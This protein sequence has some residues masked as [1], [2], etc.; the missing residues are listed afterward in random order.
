MRRRSGFTLI[1]L[2][3]VIA[4]IGILA[5]I[6]L[7]ALSRAREAARR[8]SCANNLKQWGLMFKMF[9]NENDGMFPAANQWMVN[10][11][12]LGINAMGDLMSEI[13]PQNY[14]PNGKSG[15]SAALYPDYWT[16]PNIA[17][18]PS[19]PRSDTWVAGHPHSGKFGIEEDIAAQ[20]ARMNKDGSWPCKAAMNVILS[21]PTSYIYMP[22]AIRSAS[23]YMDVAW[24]LASAF[25]SSADWQARPWPEKV[26]FIPPADI[27]RC[28]GP[29][30]WDLSQPP[31]WFRDRGF[32]DI[33]VSKYPQMLKYTWQNI[34]DRD[35][36]NVTPLPDSYRRLREGIERFFI[37]DINNPAAGAL[38]Q[39]T[40]PCMWDA[41]ANSINWHGDQGGIAR[42]N[43]IPGGS[44]VLY[45]DGHVEFIK[46]QEKFPVIAPPITTQPG[47][48]AQG[49]VYMNIWGGMG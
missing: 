26:I 38:A 14:P 31:L 21:N 6:L 10:Q 25:T 32:Q 19:D 27:E 28:G 47:A 2:L 12:T 16:D 24:W 37:T 13:S 1:E 33:T 7:P 29:S 3:V 42:F 18:C 8:A 35:D 46:F 43:H 11:W 39:S 44:N 41:W 9:A 23:Q 20:I 40:L 45:V 36:D 34:F 30:A 4:I 15:A 49:L 22:Y 48:A 17:I 5:S